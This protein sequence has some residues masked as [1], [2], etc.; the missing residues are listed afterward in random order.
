MISNPNMDD[1]DPVGLPSVEFNK[2]VTTVYKRGWYAI[3]ISFNILAD[4]AERCRCELE[5]I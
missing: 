3:N 5:C 1:I 4:I 2:N